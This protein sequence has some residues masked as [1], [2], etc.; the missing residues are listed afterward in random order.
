[1]K[2]TIVTILTIIC[3]ILGIALLIQHTQSRK[4]LNAAKTENIALASDLSNAHTKADERE[5][6]IAQLETSF[7]KSKEDLT[8][9]TAELEKTGGELAKVQTDYRKLEADYKL[10]QADVQKQSLRIADLESQRTGLTQKMETLQG[11]I[12]SLETQIGDTKKKLALAEGDRQELLAQLK[13]LETEKADLVTQFNNIS[14]LRTQLAKLR[15]EAAIAQR[16]AWTRAGIY[17]NQ[18]KKGAER[19]LAEASD[20]KLKTDNRLNV[21]VEQNGGAKVVVPKSAPVN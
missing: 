10:A 16:L 13:K 7:S 3:L 14:T 4:Q 19:L 20:K 8:A 21:E 15:E 6:V 5:K 12:S 2:N 11:S 9:K 18:E 17:S 1:M